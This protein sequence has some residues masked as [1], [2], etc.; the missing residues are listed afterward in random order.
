MA[1]ES[2]GSVSEVKQV[3]DKAEAL[4]LYVKQAGHGLAL[5]N[6]FAELKLRA[7]RQA[8]KMLAADP[9]VGPGKGSTLEPLGLSKQQSHRWQ[10]VA[11]I[12]EGDFDVYIAE[13]HHNGRELTTAGALK[14]SK[15]F[16]AALRPAAR[17]SVV[18]DDWADASASLVAEF[19]TIVI[20]PPWQYANIATRGAAEDHY[21]TLSMAQLKGEAPVLDDSGEA[22]FVS[23]VLRAKVADDAHL[24]LWV[25]NS[26]LREGFQLLDAWDFNY[27]TCLTWVKPHM[28]LGN[29]FRNATEHVLF[30]TK[31]SLPTLRNDAMDWFEAPR[32]RHSEKPDAFYHLV[33]TCSPG[34]YLDMFGRTPRPGWSM[35]GNENLA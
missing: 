11:S 28:G 6:E 27:R 13:A 18:H 33:E 21:P 4:R 25:T 5:Q 15:H 22:Y 17:F 32:E 35:W 8:G 19:T 24:Y 16:A 34:P 12:P 29:W 1:L 10:A 23:D 14:L 3:R 31:G 26:F 30:A 2:A 9:E 7:E 20:D